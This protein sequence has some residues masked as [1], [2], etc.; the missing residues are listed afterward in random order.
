MNANHI[1]EYLE[2]DSE[3]FGRRIARA[4][5]SCLTNEVVAEIDVW[6]RLH[7]VECLY[8]LGSS[9]DRQTVKLAQENS[10][11][12]VD[13]RV[14]LDLQLGRPCEGG[15]NRSG[16]RL[17]NAVESDIPALRALARSG[18]RDSRFYYDGNFP[19]RKCDEL[20]ETWIEKSCR[21]WANSVLVAGEDGVVDGYLTCHLPNSGSGQIGLV[22]VSEKAQGKGI[23]KD[24]ISLAIRWFAQQGIENLSVVTQG[25][26]VRAQRLYQRCGFATRSVE[27]WFHRWF[28][29]ARKSA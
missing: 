16:S 20:Y 13:V 15:D 27:L 6:C 5:V 11:R 21:G 25:R 29:E 17:R 10:F 26:N 14:T 23:G 1:C 7:D 18:H 19:C 24:L 28:S 12:F 22:G 2:W 8:F 3:F 9:A 4:N